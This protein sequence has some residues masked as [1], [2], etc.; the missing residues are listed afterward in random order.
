MHGTRSG[1]AI[2]RPATAVAVAASTDIRALSHDGLSMVAMAGKLDRLR[3]CS[4]NF[5]GPCESVWEIK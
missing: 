4:S 1:K 5:C 3:R 2:G